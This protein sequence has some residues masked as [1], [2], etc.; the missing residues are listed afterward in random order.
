MKRLVILGSTG[1]IGE[2]ALKVAAALPDRLRVVGLSAHGRAGRLMEQARQFGVSRV[3]LADPARA[4][5]ARR[6]AAPGTRL[7]VG[8]EGVAELAALPEADIVLCGL[9]GMSGLK[10]VL[11]ALQARHDVALATKE[12]LVSAGELVMAERQRQGVRILPVDSEHSALFQCL[13]GAACTAA[14]VRTP[15]PAARLETGLRRLLLTASGGPFAGTPGRDLETVTPAQALAHPRWSMGRKVTIDSATMMNKGLEIMEAHWLFDMPV[16]RIDVVIHPESVVHSLVEFVDGTMLAQLAPADMR[17]AIQHALLWPE[18]VDA[19]L[20]PLALSDLARLHFHAPDEGRFPCLRLARAAA[21]AGRS[22]PAVLNAANE[23]AV[24]AFLDGRIGFADIGRTVER[25]LQS[26]APVAVERIDD[27]L[28]V[29][30]W[31]RR[32]AGERL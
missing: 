4:D 15:S 21:V 24:A 23:V 14:C 26:H 27:V 11:A 3:A 9:V 6:L 7:L 17:Y 20:P 22:C 13:H 28:A 16:D 19:G 25:V 12:V 32:A 29:D 1:S 5:E 2:N 30:A 31:A 10:P 18:R 8:G